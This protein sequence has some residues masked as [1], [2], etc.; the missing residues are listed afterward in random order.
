MPAYVCACARVCAS[1]IVFVHACVRIDK[2][3]L[4]E[5]KEVC[6]LPAQYS[7]CRLLT[8]S[9]VKE[10]KSDRGNLLDHIVSESA[11]LQLSNIRYDFG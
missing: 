8:H 9:N 10:L 1:S 7:S 3:S 6:G 2:E 5:C 11:S 4:E